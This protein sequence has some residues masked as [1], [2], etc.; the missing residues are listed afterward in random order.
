MWVIEHPTRGLLVI[1][2]DAY[3][4]QAD[5]FPMGSLGKMSSTAAAKAAESTWHPAV[6]VRSHCEN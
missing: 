3:E 1:S 2:A 6:W 4:N 5:V